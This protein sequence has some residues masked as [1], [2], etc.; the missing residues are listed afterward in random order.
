MAVA[1]ATTNPFAPL[2]ARKGVS[3]LSDNPVP[4]E[5][6]P[7]VVMGKLFF[8]EIR[9]P[10]AGHVAMHHFRDGEWFDL[11]QGVCRPPR[12]PLAEPRRVPRFSCQCRMRQQRQ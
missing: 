9:T 1:T 5:P 4:R 7:A 12:G 10:S 8:C 2:L 6:V 3:V 11:A